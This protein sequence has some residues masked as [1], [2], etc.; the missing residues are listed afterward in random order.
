MGGPNLKGS[1][2]PNMA[3]NIVMMQNNSGIKKGSASGGKYINNQGQFGAA[4]NST[5][6]NVGNVAKSV[7]LASINQL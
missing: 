2:K 3:G 4:N 1:G 5:H 6:P 7:N